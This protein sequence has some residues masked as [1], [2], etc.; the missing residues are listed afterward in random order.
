VKRPP[1]LG[2]T[3]LIVSLFLGSVIIVSAACSNQGEGERC[4]VLNGD[5]D[6]KTDDGLICYRAADLNNSNSDRCCPRD[7]A[8]ATNPVCKT[9]L[10]TVTNDAQAPSDSG[11]NPI[12]PDATPDANDGASQEDSGIADA[13]ADG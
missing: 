5:D 12:I 11:P 6:C 13:G 2:R 1:A 7:R 9:P 10:S 8:R 4:D 3:A